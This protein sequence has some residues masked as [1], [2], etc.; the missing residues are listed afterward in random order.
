M[1][2]QSIEKKEKVLS[3]EER[4]KLKYQIALRFIP[5]LAHFQVL[6]V[7][8][9]YDKFCKGYIPEIQDHWYIMEEFLK[10]SEL[11]SNFGLTEDMIAYQT[12]TLE[13]PADFDGQHKVQDKINSIRVLGGIQHQYPAAH[14]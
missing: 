12:F 9:W 2:T 6:H 14:Q 8:A 11:I 1:N 7:P 10:E 3:T 13:S 4:L 5:H